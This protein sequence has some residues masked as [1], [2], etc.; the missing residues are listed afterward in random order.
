MNSR[1]SRRVLAALGVGVALTL[2]AGATSFGAQTG[3]RELQGNP[4]NEQPLPGRAQDRQVNRRDGA[5]VER[6]G[7]RLERRLNFLHQQL[8]IRANQEGVWNRFADSVRD[9]AQDAL[10]R[11]QDRRGDFR[12]RGDGRREDRR[13]NGQRRDGERFA[14]PSVVERLERRQERLANQTARID[15]LLTAVRPLYA[16][17]D[18][19]QRQTAD[20]LF[21]PAGRG[22]GRNGG[23]FFNR[24]VPGPDAGRGDRSF[25]FDGL[26]RR[27]S[28]RTY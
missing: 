19:A 18:A 2:A 15:H 9:D 10:D 21:F 5:T 11:F 24:R 23:R 13:E 1:H 3:P 26:Q 6:R 12:G 27:D 14:P 28:N 17:L 20:R 4:S 25:D 16:A 7:D 8:H 22:D